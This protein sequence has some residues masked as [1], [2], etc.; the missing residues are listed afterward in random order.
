MSAA[1]IVVLLSY[2]LV[3][4]LGETEAFAAAAAAAATAI[5][6]SIGG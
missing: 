4:D 6:G 2:H 3:S 1:T 5:K